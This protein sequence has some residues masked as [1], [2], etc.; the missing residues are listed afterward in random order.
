[1]VYWDD[2]VGWG[3]RLTPGALRSALSG[4]L[5][6]DDGADHPLGRELQAGPESWDGD[7]GALLEAGWSAGL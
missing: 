3:W 4:I 5:L 7:R 6:D 1:M 2:L